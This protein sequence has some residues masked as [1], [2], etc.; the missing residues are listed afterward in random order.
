MLKE[1]WNGFVTP[2]HTKSTRKWHEM[3]LKLKI[4]FAYAPFTHK[5]PVFAHG[6]HVCICTPNV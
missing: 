2:L 6:H 3:L 1:N 5:C 4:L